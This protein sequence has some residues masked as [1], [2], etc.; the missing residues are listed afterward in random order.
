MR[1]WE[2]DSI[3]NDQTFDKDVQ[4]VK[5]LFILDD[6]LKKA[7]L[8]VQKGGKILKEL[9]SYAS[10]LL[11]QNPAEQQAQVKNGE[12]TALG[13]DYEAA[14][15]ALGLRLAALKEDLF[16]KLLGELEEIAFFLKELRATTKKKGSRE[17]EEVIN[18][19]SADGYHSLWSLYQTYTSKIKIGKEGLSIGQAQNLFS[20]SDRAVR[21]K[22]FEE[23]NC[24]WKEHLDFLAQLLNHIGGFRLKVY[25]TRGWDRVLDEPLQMNRMET[26]THDAMWQ[27]I[28]EAKSTLV[29][30]LRHRA[31]ILGLEK[32]SWIDLEAP[33]GEDH[34]ISYSEGSQII[35]DQ[36]EKFH[37]RMAQFAKRA[38]NNQWIESEDRPGKAAGG[39]CVSLPKTGV[40]RIFMT[41]NGT[42]T[43]VATLAHEL[44]H[45]YHN[46]CIKHLPYFHQEVRWNVA[47]TAST[48]GEM[49]VIDQ[50]I[51][52]AKTSKEKQ[53]LLDDKLQRTV[54]YFMNLQARVEFET[55]FYIERK[56]GFVSAEKL[57]ELMLTA[58]K[59]A[60][61]NELSDW[62]P[63]F[64][65]WKLHFFYTGVPFYNFP[66][67]FGYL[68]SNGLYARAQGQS[69]GEK[70]DAFLVDTGQ[71]TVED[72][73]KKHLDVDL[74]KPDFWRSSVDLLTKDVDE[75]TK[76][77]PL[78]FQKN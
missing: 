75:F 66:Y 13:V 49:I 71:M 42:P 41:Y 63:Y 27:A 26:A 37:P 65:A 6:D 68:L 69:F 15:F 53:A 77:D 46:E 23:W 52:V 39:F 34:N 51:A 43:N 8:Q 45:A 22:A 62:D 7:I 31:R 57:S 74:S 60:F 10:C 56:K 11:A 24:S 55:A 20:V 3:Y 36:F 58:Q 21:L 16:D 14:L 38:L 40:S 54:A 47:E 32:L 29:R 33:L 12:I 19:L 4:Q 64:W 30:Y 1:N 70:F 35:L 28:E 50:T 78:S 76:F 67:T 59:E 61:C 73:G 48:F 9:E 44:G 72:L 5:Q 25:E 17:K 18:A 2:L